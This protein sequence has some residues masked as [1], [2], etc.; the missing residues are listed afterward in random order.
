MLRAYAAEYVR[1]TRIFEE[2]SQVMGPVVARSGLATPMTDIDQ[3]KMERLHNSLSALKADLPLPVFNDQLTR[4][5]NALDDGNHLEALTIWKQLRHILESELESH[6]FLYVRTEFAAF[7]G[8]RFSGAVEEKFPKTISDNE[9]AGKCLAVGQG[10]ACVFHLMRAM[11]SAVRALCEKLE[12]K[13][14]EREWGKLL[15]DMNGKIEGMEKGATKTQWSESHTH[16]Y[17]VKQAWRN[18]TMHPNEK[19]TDEE[20]LEVYRAVK[21]FM[22]HLAT[23]I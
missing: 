23:L 4:F 13:N 20:A 6:Q 11:E 17:H 9:N 5:D 16:L 2:I 10:T 18:D 19:Y 15:S 7:Y 21:V 1:L 12:I 8:Q 14:I 3:Q 22:S